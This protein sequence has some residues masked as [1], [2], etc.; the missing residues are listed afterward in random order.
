MPPDTPPATPP[1]CTTAHAQRG[2]ST[3]LTSSTSKERRG[4]AVGDD[5]ASGVHARRA[6]ERRDRLGQAD[7]PAVLAVWAVG[8]GGDDVQQPL[9]EQG[10]GGARLIE[11]ELGA[12]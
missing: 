12:D 3:P 7:G 1:A 10:A 9:L 8:V 2:A 6:A 4:S 5:G 11:G